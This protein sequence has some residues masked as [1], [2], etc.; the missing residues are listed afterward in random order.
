VSTREPVN[1]A[2][3]LRARLKN[4]AEELGLDLNQV[5][6]YYVMERFL[7][8]LS[9]TTWAEC[10]VV[11]GAA[12]LRVWDG[13]IA[14]A[15]RDIDFLGNIHNSPES[16]AAIMRECFAAE[17]ADGLE[18][19]P[20][21]VVEPITVEDRYP[22]VRA[23]IEARL[24]GARIRLQ[25]D[26]GVADVAVPEPG[27]VDYPTLLD[28]DA[29]HIL[30]YQPAT[31]VAEKF[32]TMVS[33]GLLNSRVKDYYDIWMLSRTVAFDG[34]ELAAALQAT[35][36]Q[37]ETEVPAVR[38][39]VLGDEYSQRPEAIAQWTAL[40]SRLGAG[41]VEAPESLADVADAIAEFVLP[42]AQAAAAGHTFAGKWV[43]WE[44]WQ[45]VGDE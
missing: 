27:W 16:V 21:V 3:S 31:A 5:L 32:E 30:A 23:K 2:A 19:S 36:N 43:P 15:T 14:R 6:Q 41:G 45:A 20:D 25:L 10:L 39:A 12:M 38:P 18:F 35:F 34:S 9:K 29:P 17:S 8:R 4:R 42:P 26:I 22:G 1:L 37:R 7:Y 40:V 11:K 33:K 24:S 44:G 13:A 28:M